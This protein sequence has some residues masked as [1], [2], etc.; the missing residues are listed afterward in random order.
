MDPHSRFEKNFFIH[1]TRGGCPSRIWVYRDQRAEP[2]FIRALYNGADNPT[3]EL[4]WV[5]GFDNKYEYLSVIPN[6][7]YGLERI[8]AAPQKRVLLTASLADADRAQ[9]LWPDG[10]PCLAVTGGTRTTDY[11]PLKD[12]RAWIWCERN[13]L[14]DITAREIAKAIQD[15]AKAVTIVNIPKP[16]DWSLAQ[17]LDGEAESLR[18]LAR[19]N[20]SVWA[21]FDIAEEPIQEPR[22][23][24]EPVLGQAPV[25]A[26]QLTQCKAPP[27][28][29]KPRKA[30]AILTSVTRQADTVEK[31]EL[32]PIWEPILYRGN[33][34]LIFGDPGLFKSGLTLD[35]AARVS[36]GWDWPLG[37]KSRGAGDVLIV[38]GE[39]DPESVVV[40]RLEAAGADL[41][42][43]V[44]FDG[45]L[46]TDMDGKQVER[47]FTLDLHA[48]HLAAECA[49]RPYSLIVIDPI[50][51]FLGKTDSHTNAETRGVLKKLQKIASNCR[52]AVA[53]VTHRA[54]SAAS[55]QTS[56]SGSIAFAAFP[57]V[58]RAVMEDPNRA[59]RRMFLHQKN[60]LSKSKAGYAF[61][62][63]TADNGY[64]YLKWEDDSEERIAQDVFEENASKTMG[65]PVGEKVQEAM[66]WLKGFLAKEAREA[67]TCYSVGEKEGFSEYTLKSA[68]KRLGIVS[69]VKG[70]QGSWHWELPRK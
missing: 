44:F 6:L 28:P 20:S 68:K 64:P 12:K 45:I 36:K 4:T 38:T 18:E 8:A 48:E 31:C 35:M 56:I 33:V 70:Y 21:Y 61:S 15:I 2:Q 19:Q 53:V 47:E 14:G 13:P 32:E 26:D 24:P 52:A 22:R 60:N 9:E 50:S 34:T 69:L 11:S 25:V 5:W 55:S 49:K 37:E 67:T 23:E 63:S 27:A 57:R 54:K 10:G 58:V 43:I 46:Q 65:R 1:P 42:R 66:D 51:A 39:D 59:D 3:E 16:E 41:S 30:Q 62:V 17:A 29:T 7:L 40:W